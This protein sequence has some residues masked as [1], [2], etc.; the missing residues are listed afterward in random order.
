MLDSD[1][2]LGFWYFYIDAT[3][4]TFGFSLHIDGRANKVV[5][6]NLRVNREVSNPYTQICVNVHKIVN[7]RNNT[8]CINVLI[9]FKRSDM[10]SRIYGPR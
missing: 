5:K 4:I 9:C 6:S 1:F 7:K 8:D 10:R 3:L 2:H